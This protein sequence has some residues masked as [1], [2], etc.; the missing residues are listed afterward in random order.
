MADNAKNKPA[1]EQWARTSD[2]HRTD[3]DRAKSPVP[4][5]VGAFVAWLAAAVIE[6]LCV[7]VVAG[8]LRVPVLSDIAWLA[9]VLTVVVCLALTIA[10]Q[11]LWKQA[12]AIKPLKQQGLVGVAMACAGFVAWALFFLAS[13]N[14]PVASKAA[15]VVAALL[16]AAISALACTMC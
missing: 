7:L 3:F 2:Q 5:R 14:L 4:A 8:R 11:R 9:I 12:G 10:G 16:V 1:E 13:K 15:G 6:V